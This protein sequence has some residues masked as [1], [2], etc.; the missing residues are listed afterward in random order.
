VENNTRSLKIGGEVGLKTTIGTKEAFFRLYLNGTD[1][2][3]HMEKVSGLD[4]VTGHK[5]LRPD[6]HLP[7][8]P[9]LLNQTQIFEQARNFSH[10]NHPKNLKTQTQISLVRFIPHQPKSLT[11]T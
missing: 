10:K 9:S 3:E 5:K 4:F 6:P 11:P 1:V 8:S 2:L 7:L